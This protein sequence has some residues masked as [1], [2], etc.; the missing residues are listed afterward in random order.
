MEPVMN[1]ME[2]IDKSGL[3]GDRPSF[4]PG[5]TLKVHCRIKEG[6]KERIQIFEGVC[7]K[8]RRAGV[9]S[10]FTVRKISFGVGVERVFPLHSPQVEKIEV[11]TSGSVR[12]SKL[13]YLRELSGKAARIKEGQREYLLEDGGIATDEDAAE[14]PQSEEK[15]GE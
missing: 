5:D 8:R 13:Y 9:S 15:A 6:E 11:V 4:R 3:R 2:K 12:R 1:I 14:A 7:I 10:S